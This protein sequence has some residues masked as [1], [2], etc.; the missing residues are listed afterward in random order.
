MPTMEN[1]EYRRRLITRVEELRTESAKTILRFQQQ[2][3]PVTA[4]KWAGFVVAGDEEACSYFSLKAV[5][6]IAKL[7]GVGAELLSFKSQTNTQRA[8]DRCVI[9]PT[10]MPIRYR[11]RSGLDHSRYRPLTCSGCCI[12]PELIRCGTDLG[13][14]LDLSWYLL[15]S[16]GGTNLV[17]QKVRGG[18]DQRKRQHESE[19][20]LPPLT[21]TLP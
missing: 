10:R 19:G 6:R 4:R 14:N 9:D 13:P 21:C 20:S 7:F 12:D 1:N 11:E 15:W 2:I 17:P 3:S 16:C 8:M 18:S 5:D